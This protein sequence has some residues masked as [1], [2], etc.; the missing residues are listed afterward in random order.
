MTWAVALKPAILALLMC[1][2]GYGMP[3]L[4]NDKAGRI[5]PVPVLVGGWPNVDS[6][7]SMGIVKPLKPGSS[8]F[9]AVRDAPELA[10]KE[11]ARL[12]S[13]HPVWLCGKVQN[14][15]WIGVIYHPQGAEGDLWDC[16][17]SEEG[18]AKPV[19]YRGP[20]KSGWVARRYLWLSAG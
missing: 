4:A 6:C 20:C 9:L 11:I 14:K 12:K 7:T 18:P 19:A 15:G 1:F 13:G 17:V 3:T 10:A 2:T 5:R 8:A 16:G